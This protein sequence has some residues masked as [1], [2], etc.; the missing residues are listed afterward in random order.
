LEKGA[1]RMNTIQKICTH[2]RKW[3]SDYLLKLFQGSGEEGWRKKVEEVNS[4]MIYLIH[5]KNQC[6]FHNVPH[7]SKQ[8]RKIFF[9]RKVKVSEK[10]ERKLKFPFQL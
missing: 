10:K 4:C 8:Q 7:P 5:C 1:R 6:E 2:V 3:K 9:R